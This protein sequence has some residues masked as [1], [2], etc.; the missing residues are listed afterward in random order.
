MPQNQITEPEQLLDI[1]LD[2]L[3]EITPKQAKFIQGILAGKTAAQ[4]YREAYDVKTMAIHNLWAEAARTKANPSVA[5]WI[6]LAQRQHLATALYTRETWLAEGQDIKL[7]ARESGNLGAAV[8]MHVAQGKVSGL[9]VDRIETVHTF[10]LA[11][12]LGQ[13][14]QE[15]HD[16]RPELELEAQ[17]VEE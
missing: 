6:R 10:D 13:L 8:N 1:D 16:D 9:F 17:A 15:R 5:P 4:A 2:S 7:Q 11:A 3:P 12:S 14:A